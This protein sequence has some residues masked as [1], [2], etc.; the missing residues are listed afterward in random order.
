MP[1]R[2]E[3]GTHLYRPAVRFERIGLPQLVRRGEC[4]MSVAEEPQLETPPEVLTHGPDESVLTDKV[5]EHLRAPRVLAGMALALGLVFAFY[6]SRPIWHTDVWG[7][8]SYGRLIWNTGRL[9]ATEPL[10]P[11]AKGMPFVDSAWLSQLIGYAVVSS[12]RLQLAGLQGLFALA[13]TGCCALL[14]WRAYQQTRNGWFS[15]LA[16]C[17]FLFVGSIPLGVLRPQLAGML[18]FVYLLSRLTERSP[19]SSDWIVVPALFAV[20]A[21]LHASFPVGLGLLGCFCVGRAID[22]F[23][24]TG[25]VRDSLSDGQVIRLFL[26]TEMSAA[27]VL[28]NPY[29][30]GLYL[31]V[32]RFSANENLMD[33]A[34]WH[35]LTLRDG[36]GQLFAVAAIITAILYRCS[37]RRVRTWE[38]LTLVMFGLAAMWN[39]RMILWWAPIVAL[40]VAQH[41]FAAWRKWTQAPLV[42][43]TTVRTGKWSLDRLSAIR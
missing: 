2:G 28:L 42:S 29:S 20:W 39:A 10:M 6:C 15:L 8:L 24:K 16:L 22:V 36:Q 37:P 3:H 40:L 17:T 11:L 32:M 7:H 38:V 35:P 12:E 19:Q 41:G 25:S 30:I 18:C 31:D 13:I 23:R 4:I 27:A 26:I 34:E 1:F 9:P 33:L 14:A 43:E 21:N 5:P